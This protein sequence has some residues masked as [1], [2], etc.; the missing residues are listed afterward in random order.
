LVEQRIENPRVGGSIPPLATK[1]R[2]PRPVRR[3]GLLFSALAQSVAPAAM[4]AIGI[5]VIVT[6]MAMGAILVAMIVAATAVIA[7]HMVLIP[8]LA[9]EGHRHTAGLVAMAVL[10]PLLLVARRHPKVDR[11]MVTVALDAV[12]DHRLRDDH[13]R[14]R[15]T[16]DIDAAIDPRK[17][18]A[19][20]S[21]HGK[22][23]AEAVRR[24]A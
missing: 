18:P 16:T 4:A 12:H 6:I 8:A 2:K 5:A 15:V 1:S 24:L 13:L 21:K 14:L 10:R 22:R 17:K 7:H 20:A 11:L 9:R 3:A 19:N 23:V